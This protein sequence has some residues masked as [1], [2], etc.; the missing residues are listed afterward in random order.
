MKSRFLMCFTAIALFAALVVPTQ[1]DA[2]DHH[3]RHH[4]YTLIDMGTFGGPSSINS[5]GSRVLNKR[6]ALVGVSD[7]SMT[8]PYSPNCFLDCFLDDG[9][10]WSDGF[11]TQLSSLPG[12]ASNFPYAIND[13]GQI[14]GESQNGAID[15]LTGWPQA[16]A[17]VWQ[18]GQIINLGTFG[19][20][21]SNANAN[22]NR[23]QVVGAALNTTSNP[24]ANSPLPLGCGTFAQCFLFAPAATEVRTFRWTTADGMQDLLGTLGG[25]DSNATMINDHGQIAG[26]FFTSFTP[27]SST[28]VPT[29]NPFLAEDGKVTDLG[30]LGGTFGIPLWMNNRGQ[31]VGYS[32]LAGDIASHPFLWSDGKMKD[33]GTLG[34][35]CLCGGA[36]SINDDGEVVG[37]AQAQNGHFAFLWKKGT[38]TNLGSIGTDGCSLASSINSGS[39]IVGWS[40]FCDVSQRGALWENGDPPAD[41]NTLVSADSGLNLI[42]AIFINDRGEIVAS[43]LTQSGNLH[44][45]LLIPCDEKHGDGNGCEERTQNRSAL[46]QMNSLTREV[47]SGTQRLSPPSRTNRFRLPG[48]AIDPRN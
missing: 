15:P 3:A 11:L 12:G 47:S 31:V 24:F 39:Q 28:G 16:N 34:G 25:P 17:V 41:L 23:G 7:T 9:W 30:G 38:M 10:V 43:G 48:F 32:S 46:P 14:V 5:S 37:S 36:T 40:G 29:I 2:Q 27:N 4:K 35:E 44:A 13:H 21:Q 20:N 33:L 8:D 42:E 18:D 6:S 26:E 19:G 45:V 22:S 1:L